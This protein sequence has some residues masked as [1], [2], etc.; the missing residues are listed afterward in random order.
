MS[1]PSK[2]S[3]VVEPELLDRLEA[4]Q[5]RLPRALGFRPSLSA[6][7][8]SVIKRGLAMEESRPELRR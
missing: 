7:G 4:E 6:V 2:L 3:L 8:R 5:A 1:A